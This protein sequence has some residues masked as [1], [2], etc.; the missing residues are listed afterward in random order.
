MYDDVI[1]A[2]L[3]CC[4]DGVIYPAFDPDVETTFEDFC[5]L[6]KCN[7]LRVSNLNWQSLK[8]AAIESLL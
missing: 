8:Q 7:Y 5:A 4:D 6:R 2:I 3:D 1:D